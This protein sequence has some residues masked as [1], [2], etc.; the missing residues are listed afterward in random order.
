MAYHVEILR[1]DRGVHV[2]IDLAQASAALLE[3]SGWRRLA[4]ENT[5][6]REAA[7]GTQEL[8]HFEQGGLWASSP[9]EAMLADMLS[10]ARTLKARVRGD[11]L[12]TY[13]SLHK[14]SVHADDRAQKAAIDARSRALYRRNKR[15]AWTI[16][17][18]L[19]AGPALLA[20][21]YR[22]LWP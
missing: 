6:A 11:E 1:T 2:P 10:A 7:D 15:M 8:L 18:G 5:F 3:L 12:E 17:V 16:R 19:M 22:W 9:S 20:L 21:A 4:G 14:W 13:E